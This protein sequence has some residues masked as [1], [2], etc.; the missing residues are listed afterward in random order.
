[1]LVASDSRE[2][3]ATNTPSNVVK[4]ALFIDYLTEML[5]ATKCCTGVQ[6]SAARVLQYNIES[7]L[8]YRSRAGAQVCAWSTNC[9]VAVRPF[10]ACDDFVG[11]FANFGSSA[12]AGVNSTASSNTFAQSPARHFAAASWIFS[13]ELDT[14]FHQI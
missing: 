14:K 10:A 5:G 6:R 4:P 8:L 3:N 1:M 2:I 12:G 11:Y 7:D 9:R 13:G